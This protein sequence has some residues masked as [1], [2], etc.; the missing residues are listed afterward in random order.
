MWS[1]ALTDLFQSVVIMVGPDRGRLA[2]GR[3]GRRRRRKVIAAA[4]EAGKFEFWPKA[5]AKEWL[6]FLAA[7][8]TIAIGSIPQQDVFQRVTSAKDENTAVRGT[9]IGG[10]VYFCFAFVPMFIAYCGAGDRSE[11][12][13]S[14][15]PPRTRARS[16]ASCPT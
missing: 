14:C 15:S 11:L 8:M 7:W 13:R 12:R 10:A 16:S 3:H 2:G 6:A 4:A 9:L 5:G 1:V